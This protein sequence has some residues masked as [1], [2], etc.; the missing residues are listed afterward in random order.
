MITLTTQ[1]RRQ[2]LTSL[3]P[4]TPTNHPTMARWKIDPDEPEELPRQERIR[5]LQVQSD[6]IAL[7]QVLML[8][9]LR[10]LERILEAPASL[11]R[12]VIAVMLSAAIAAVTAFDSPRLSYPCFV[13]D[14]RSRRVGHHGGS[15]VGSDYRDWKADPGSVDPSRRSTRQSDSET[16]RLLERILLGPDRF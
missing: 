7:S 6:Q 3:P 14:P 4:Q 12:L 11:A 13:R 8:A 5:L 1:K 10:Q 16:R 2:A 15:E 9:E